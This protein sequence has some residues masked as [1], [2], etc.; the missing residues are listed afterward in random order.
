MEK[1]IDDLLEKGESD[2]C[3]LPKDEKK[4]EAGAPQKKK[5]NKPVSGDKGAKI[6]EDF[7]AVQKVLLAECH[8]DCSDMQ[9]AF[10]VLE[11]EFALNE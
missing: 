11:E 2:L 7:K 6:V 10:F 5:L 4:E 9:R 1:A 8:D 3:P